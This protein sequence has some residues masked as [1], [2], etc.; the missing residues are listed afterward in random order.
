[1]T[2]RRHGRSQ[3]YTEAGVRRLPCVRCGAPAVHQWQVCADG[4][5]YRPVC[6]ACDVDLNA[7]VLRWAGD[8]D[9][10]AKIA[11][12]AERIVAGD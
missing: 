2:W 11:A 8:P 1:M 12:Y 5:L 9:A 6:T 7:L 3:P 10:E 4:R